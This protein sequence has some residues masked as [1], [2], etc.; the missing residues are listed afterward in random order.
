MIPMTIPLLGDCSW[1][2]CTKNKVFGLIEQ[3]FGSIT[4]GALWVIS[5]IYHSMKCDKFF[6]LDNDSGKLDPL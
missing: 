5:K 6:K 4:L 1:V 2:H 3:V